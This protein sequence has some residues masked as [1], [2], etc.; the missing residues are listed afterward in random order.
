MTK[1]RKSQYTLRITGANA[2]E[3]VVI[4][5][6]MALEYLQ[7]GMAAENEELLSD[8]I[9]K[10][11]GCINELLSSLHTEYEV[12][13]Q[14]QRLY[15]FCIRRLAAAARKKD[16]APLEEVQQVL[17]PLRDAYEKIAEQNPSGPVMQNAQTVYS[18]LTY[19]K[20][21]SLSESLT[22]SGSGRG[23]FV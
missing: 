18:G 20:T 16:K 22:E 17:S 9:R 19:G 15:L 21:A 5:Y 2:T 3:L 13:Q 8:A 14:M 23:M 10:A 4:L 7:E 6:D 12:A 11:R 1:E